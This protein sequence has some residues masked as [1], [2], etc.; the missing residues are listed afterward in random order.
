MNTRTKFFLTSLRKRIT[1]QD[2]SCPN[3]G[4]RNNAHLD[5]KFLVVELVR[6]SDCALIFRTPTT[7]AAENESYYQEEYQLGF[8]TD[9]PDAATLDQLKASG[10]RG[11]GKDFSDR[12]DLLRQLGAT[13]GQRLLD[14]GCS[15]GYGSWQFQQA[16]YQVQAYE[17]SKPRGDYARAMLGVN[18]T[19]DLGEIGDGF[20]VFFSAHVLEHV[21]NPAETIKFALSRLKPGG[22]FVAL[23]PNGSL[24][25]RGA[26]P[27]GWHQA[28]GLNHPNMLDEVF[29]A[30]CFPGLP[31]LYAAMPCDT[32]ALSQF[33]SDQKS[34]TL[35]LVGGEL[36]CAVRKAG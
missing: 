11:T 32:A 4:S 28:W 26:E 27:H 35:P 6:C 21:P 22:L 30:R 1:R 23:T 15:W 18:V 19:A 8:T 2:L 33:A 25:H 10:F 31:Q 20:D 13:P 14:F 24:Q 17:I 36:L 16:G 7:T 12:L 9:M 29:Y 5:R 3:C 34:V